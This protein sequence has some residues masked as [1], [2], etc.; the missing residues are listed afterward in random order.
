MFTMS[1]SPIAFVVGFLRPQGT[2]NRK[3]V[4]SGG[5]IAGTVAAGSLLSCGWRR[6]GGSSQPHWLAGECAECWPE[7]CH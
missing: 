4:A 1:G 6:T 3:A 7:L 5:A 2:S